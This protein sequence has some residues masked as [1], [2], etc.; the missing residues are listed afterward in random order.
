MHENE[1]INEN[2]FRKATDDISDLKI[3]EIGLNKEYINE[4]L[5]F[6][7]V[8]RTL[9]LIQSEKNFRKQI[10]EKRQMK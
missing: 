5:P 6:L 1:N 9:M 10:R 4:V 7:G 3:K 2:D 8:E